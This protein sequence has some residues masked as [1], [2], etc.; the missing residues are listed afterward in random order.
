V[1]DRTQL[2]RNEQEV[3]NATMLCH[4]MCPFAVFMVATDHINRT[5]RYTN[6]TTKAERQELG[7]V[8]RSTSS[9]EIQNKS[10]DM[11][12]AR[13]RD[14]PQKTLTRKQNNASY[15]FSNQMN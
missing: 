4:A 10:G 1:P 2:F 9:N 15:L 12:S 11:G 8:H 6:S 5:H 13:E 7:N 3:Y 14:F